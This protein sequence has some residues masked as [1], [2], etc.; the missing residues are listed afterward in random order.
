MN[1]RITIDARAT[2]NAWEESVR[3]RPAAID[4]L[5]GEVSKAEKDQKAAERYW[6]VYIAARPEAVDGFEKLADLCAE[7]KRWRDALEFSTRALALEE[8]AVGR[9]RRAK[10][11]LQLHE[12]DKALADS[13]KANELDPSDAAVKEW[14]PQFELLTKFLPR[15]KALDAQI[16][17]LRGGAVLWLDRARLFTLAN[18]PDLALTDCREGDEAGT[19]DDAGKDSDRRSAVGS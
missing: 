11:Y 5:R 10:I 18:R 19:G 1:S 13:N 7:E 15:I 2:L 12:W 4:D 8:T 16:G 3:P 9:I 17:K 6:R 14:L